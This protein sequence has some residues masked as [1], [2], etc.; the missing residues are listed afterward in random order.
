MLQEEAEEVGQAG[1][2]PDLQ[3]IHAAGKHLLALIND[4]LDLSKI[5]AGKMELYFEA[6]DPKQLVRDVQSTI[7]PLVERNRNGLKVVCP[8]DLPE[9]YSDVTRTR[10]ILF[11]LLSNASKFTEDGTITLLVEH[12]RQDGKDWM[13][14]E[15]RDTGIGMTPEQLARLFQAFSQADAARG[16]GS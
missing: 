7:Q 4:I 6:F 12:T 16:L 8:E 15:V 13:T 5:E 3:K 9:M 2:V 11:N 1:F 14:F 10:Q